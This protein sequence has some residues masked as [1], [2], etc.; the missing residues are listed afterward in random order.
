M[1]L[2]YVLFEPIL[3]KGNLVITIHRLRYQLLA[4]V[5]AIAIGI[6]L[7]LEGDHLRAYY[8]LGLRII[9]MTLILMLSSYW[10]EK[11]SRKYR[12]DAPESWD[13]VQ[14]AV[15]ANGET[16][17]PGESENKHKTEKV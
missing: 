9:A 16:V 11:R 10:F 17:K 7:V 3:K 12:M 1:S 13:E 15:L 2:S 4:S 6:R 8:F 14:A 5:I